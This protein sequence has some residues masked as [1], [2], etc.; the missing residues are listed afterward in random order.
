[1]PDE[2]ASEALWTIIN[3]FPSLE[4]MYGG[5][6]GASDEE[7]GGGGSDD[8]NDGDLAAEEV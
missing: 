6:G 2:T 1:M 8:N 7:G 3:E 5:G 4:P